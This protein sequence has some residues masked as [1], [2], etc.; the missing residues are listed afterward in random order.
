MKAI[1][2][3]PKGGLCMVCAKRCNDCSALPF[4]LMPPLGAYQENG[5][6]VTIVRC[7]EFAR[8]NA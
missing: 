6:I 8:P 3:Q 7:T 4:A 1:E 2:H 5:V